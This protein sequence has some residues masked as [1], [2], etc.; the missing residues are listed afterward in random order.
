MEDG[1]PGAVYNVGG[2]SEVPLV[3]CLAEIERL[4]GRPLSLV[5]AGAAA[6]DAARTSADTSAARRELGWA[7]ATPFRAGIT[8]QVRAAADL[9]ARRMDT[10]IEH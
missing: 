1:R 4:L 8:A 5:F 3:A 2:G 10:V 9:P 6:G 7:P